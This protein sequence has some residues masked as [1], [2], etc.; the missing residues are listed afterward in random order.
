MMRK[1]DNW[2]RRV[3]VCIVVGLTT[4][5]PVQLVPNHLSLNLIHYVIKFV[6]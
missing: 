5:V 1:K 6:K 4:T 2:D 3:C